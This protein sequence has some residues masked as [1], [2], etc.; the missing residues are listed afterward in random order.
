VTPR[1]KPG[2]G[3]PEVDWARLHAARAQGYVC[4]ALTYLPSPLVAENRFLTMTPDRGPVPSFARARRHLPEPF[5]GRAPE[6]AYG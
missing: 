3:Q 1:R 5:W 6:R 4:D 2:R